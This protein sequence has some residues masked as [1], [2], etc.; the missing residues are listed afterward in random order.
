MLP[1]LLAASLTTQGGGQPPGDTAPATYATAAVRT[2]VERASL[3]NRRVP[4]SLYAYRAAVESEIALVARQADGVEQTFAVEQIESVVRWQRDGRYEQRVIG[5]RSQS[6]GLAVSAMG[7]FRQAW[8][9]PI[10]YGNRIALFF[11]R[12]DSSARGGRPRPP[13]PRQRPD[14]PATVVH[15]FAD[16][17]AR[18]YRFS[19][20]DTVAT[21]KPGGR[22]IPIVRIR[23]DASP[24]GVTQPTMVF[25]GDIELDAD[26]AQIVRMR[27]HFVTIGRRSGV[28]TRLLASQVDAVAYVELE[29]GEFEQRYWLPTYQRIEAHAAVPLLGDQRAV[30]RVVSR[31]RRMESNPVGAGPLDP[32]IALGADTLRVA[33][34]RLTFA[35]ADSIDRYDRWARAIGELSAGVDADDFSDVAPDSWR[36]AGRPLI[37]L[38]YQEASDLF[39]YNRVE[40]AYTGVGVEAK[41]RDAAPGLVVRGTVGW[42]WTERTARGRAS[43]ERRS[44]RWWPSM[45][46][47]RSL[48]I[49]NDFREPFDS[50]STLAAL[51]SHDD[52]DYV[53]RFGAVVGITRFIDRRGDVRVRVEGGLGSDRYAQARRA[54]GPLVRS[55][56]GFRFNRGVDPGRY[57]VASVRLELHPDVNA[58]FLRPG[59]GA[60]LRVDAASGDIAWQRAELRLSARRAIGH[61][62]YAVRAD[63]GLVSGDRIP[64]QQLFELGENQNLPGY[65]YKEF[66]GNQAAVLRGLAM[67]PLPLWRAPVRVGRW[68]F[69]GIAPMVSLGVQSGWAATTNSAAREAVA[70]LGTVGDSV[71]G[72]PGTTDARP[73]SRP[74]DGVKSSIDFRL[75]FFGGAL[76]VGTA[77]A[78]DRHQPW[79]LVVGLAQVL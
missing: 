69:P 30:F 65:G 43:V 50:G 42:A 20:G 7:M 74:T 2:L 14:G 17:R 25:R 45:R 62:I 8:T 44:G 24:R 55:D 46:V 61:V 33:L 18:V 49:T 57:G 75:R 54:Q 76:S 16:D 15:P 77:R 28:R 31:F 63:A 10:L 6:V 12:P 53:D 47:G 38:R 68:V 51:F 60:S 36:E 34:H 26:R 73:V 79:R 67:V 23:V 48:D 59:V 27:G 35:P 39:H 21:L 37:R 5:Y 29:N 3:N 70:R 19:G 13:R 52:Y 22:D 56:S 11:G 40:G 9:V 78:V 32:T 4:D 58:E 64:A 66:A 41:L 72:R 1:F 71:D